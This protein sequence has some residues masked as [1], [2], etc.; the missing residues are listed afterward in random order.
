[1]TAERLFLPARPVRLYSPVRHVGAERLYVLGRRS[2]LDRL[3]L[4]VFGRRVVVRRLCVLGRLAAYEVYVPL[5]HV[6]RTSFT[7]T[8][9]AS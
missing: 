3:Y 2:G 1:M 8:C 9:G 5:W 6:G 7:C 4:Y